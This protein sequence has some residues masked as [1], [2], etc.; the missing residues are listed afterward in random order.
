MT[1]SCRG[2]GMRGGDLRLALPTR[3]WWIRALRGRLQ[4]SSLKEGGTSERGRWQSR[5]RDESRAAGA[6]GARRPRFAARLGA[7]PRAA[8]VVVAL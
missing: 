6:R 3:G 1:P 7:L 4:R 2:A 5:L 8:R